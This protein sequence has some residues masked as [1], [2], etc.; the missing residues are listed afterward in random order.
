MS[1]LLSRTHEVFDAAWAEGIRPTPPMLPSDWADQHRML[2][3]QSAA[4]PGQ[5]RTE[6]TP[7]LREIM[8]CLADTS[9]IREVTLRKSTQVG[10]TE[11]GINWVGYIIDHIPAPVMYVMPTIDMAT[12]WSK[13]RL[14]PIVEIMPVLRN[15]IAPARSRDS[16][17]TTLLKEFPHGMLII[18]GANSAAS[19]AS[20]PV[21]FLILDELDKYPDDLDDQGSA[22]DQAE[23][24]TSS[25][26]RRKILRISS[27]TVKDHSAIDRE[28][29]R[30]DQRFYHVPCPHCGHMQTLE[31]ENLQDDGTFVC[32]TGCG[33]VIHEHHKTQML[34]FGRWAPKQ[35]GREARSYH[36]WAAYAALGLGYTWRE[37]AAMR[38]EA[39]ADPEKMVVF[40]NTVLGES[41][42]GLSQRVEADDLS[43]RAGKWN[44]RTIPRGCLALTCG[45]DVQHNRFALMLCGWGRAERCWIL[46]YVELTGDPTKPEDWA[47][48]D[49]YLSQS[50]VNACGISLRITSACIDSGNWT[51][52]VYRF[53]RP[54]QARGIMA[55]KGMSTGGKPVIGRA[56]QVDVNWRGKTQ[57]H[58]VQLWAVG[59]DTA[60]QALIQRLIADAD[61]EPDTQ[62]ILFPADLPADCYIQL[63]AER[64]DLV[65]KRWVKKKGM[66]NEALDCLVYAYAAAVSPRLR[67]HVLREQ[68][69]AA[70]E[71]IYEPD[72]T[73]LFAAAAPQ[74]SNQQAERPDSQS[75]KV[76]NVPHGT[77]PQPTQPPPP[78]RF[79]RRQ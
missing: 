14:A 71:R 59:T 58:G 69:W 20:L 51:H 10:G 66:R 12:K 53:V 27:P 75:I 42:E 46:D 44:A 74:P 16:G 57:R 40:T 45:I 22:Q 25:F 33:A 43:K 54:L 1:A 67:V 65:A 17:N 49:E 37:I 61:A 50:F 77:I 9:T 64:F 26:T 35:P 18:S 70:L 48:V 13:Q 21:R 39:R 28:F 55:V 76:K 2:P 60:K 7:Y 78:S 5:W 63:T 11:V 3:R 19:L 38:T 24:R 41:Y 30:G 72:Q 73:D 23:R 31:I 34:A 36:I 8:D 32:A 15:K 68:D 62:R 6:R 56:S 47:Q 4:E 52:D 29:E 79:A